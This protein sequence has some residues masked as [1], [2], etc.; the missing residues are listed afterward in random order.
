[1]RVLLL[2]GGGR[3]H[4]L[5]WKLS[6]SRTLEQL[7]IAPGNAGTAQVGTN[8]AIDPLDFPEIVRFCKENHIDM[9]VVGPEAP[10]VEGIKNYLQHYH[11]PVIGPSQKAARLEGSKS[12]AKQFMLQ[13]GIPT[14]KAEVFHHTQEKQALDYVSTCEYPLV[15]KADGLAAGKGV[16]IVNNVEEAKETIQHYFAGAFGEASKTLLV[17][18]Y[19]QGIEISV[20]VLCDGEHYELLT[21]AKDYKRLKENDEGPN[22][23][24]MGAVSDV[25]FFT[26]PLEEKIRKRIIEPTLNGLKEEGA[27]YTGV[28]YLGLMLVE[29]EPYVL[30]YNVRFGDPE[31]QVVLPR[32]EVD[33]LDLFIAVYERRLHHKLIVHNRKR[34]VTV[35]A[36]SKGYPFQYQKG[37][38]IF[39]LKEVFG[40][41][42]FH[43]GTKQNSKGRIV[44]NGGRVLAVTCF[45]DTIAEA[46]DLCLEN[47]Q[48][49]SFEGMYF[50]KD[51]GND[52]IPYEEGKP[53]P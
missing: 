2:G 44:T 33:L 8:V 15:I 21:T 40:G 19:L 51:I 49:I 18:E 37:F 23:G 9:V 28:L 41:L 46:R 24:G 16:K 26:R 13:R 4:A 27:P 31:A 17:E 39:G 11:I 34:A 43:A 36:A 29:G 10:L 38:P 48:R 53:F 5:A 25:P 7:F 30:E 12:Y 14:A 32:L 45:G 3:E 1:M 20:F 22:T 6:Q 42:V 35:V 52:L 50:R 47:L